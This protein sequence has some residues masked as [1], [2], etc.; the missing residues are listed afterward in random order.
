MTVDEIL[1]SIIVNSTDYAIV[2]MAVNE[3]RREGH[4]PERLCSIYNLAMSDPEANYPPEVVTELKSHLENVKKARPENKKIILQVRVTQNEKNAI[5]LL[6]DRS[7]LSVSEFVR[8][9][10][11]AAWNK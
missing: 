1:R 9:Q 5:Q 3:L 10:C 11:L 2:K 6:A 8:R 4:S 7:G